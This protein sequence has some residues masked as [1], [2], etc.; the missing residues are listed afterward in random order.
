MSDSLAQVLDAATAAA[1]K[2]AVDSKAIGIAWSTGKLNEYIRGEL[3]RERNEYDG[4]TD[5]G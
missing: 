3:D 4:G 2:F 1:E 5:P